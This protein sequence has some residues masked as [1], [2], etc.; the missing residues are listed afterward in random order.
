MIK[1]INKGELEKKC[2]YLIGKTLVDLGQVKPADEKVVLAKRLSRILITKFYKLHWDAVEAAFDD[3]VLESEEFHLCNKTMFKWL[4]AM[5]QKIYLGWDN[6][7]KG[8]YYR[9][10]Q[11]TM[12][13]LNNQKL[14]E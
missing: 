3:G 12:E 8:D 13:L 1:E 7:Q 2:L 9:I 4:A 5:K 6:L 11:R 14:I 10:D